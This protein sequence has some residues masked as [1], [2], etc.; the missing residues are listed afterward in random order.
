MREL[1]IDRVVVTNE[2]V[3]IRYMISASSCSEQ[4]RYGFSPHTVSGSIRPRKSSFII[5]NFICS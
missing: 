3:E 2:G 5:S 1:L 4:I